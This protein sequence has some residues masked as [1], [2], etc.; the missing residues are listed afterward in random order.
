MKTI[1]ESKLRKALNFM[2]KAHDG[3]FRKFSGK[4]YAHHPVEVSKIVREIKSSK[5]KE[6]LCIAALLHDTVEDCNVNIEDIQDEFGLEVKEIVDQL[7]SDNK[8]IRE[9]GKANY[10]SNKMLEM[11]SYALVIKL[12]D[13]LHN[14]SDLDKGSDKF[15]NKYVLETRTIL[16]KLGERKLSQTHIDL[17]NLIDERISKFE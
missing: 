6:M 5:N 8:K 13:R 7:T 10:L 9:V 11:S 3:Q 12:A 4:E 14:C 16:N 2:I 15:V 1:K 17:I